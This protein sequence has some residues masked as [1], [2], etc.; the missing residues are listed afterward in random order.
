MKASVRR[1]ALASKAAE[2]MELKVWLRL[3]TCANQVLGQ[4]RKDLQEGF[5]ATLPTFDLLA[6][7]DRRPHGP[8]MSELSKRLMVS[9]GNISDLVDRVEAKGLVER[10]SDPTDGRVQRIYLTEAGDRLFAELAPAH[11]A[12]L[13]E[14][15]AG[16]DEGTLEAM[17]EVLGQLKSSINA[18]ERRRQ[19]RTIRRIPS[20][21]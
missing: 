19:K 5:G 11:N 16:L 21:D 20:P 14:A 6:Q 15:M 18:A 12:V 9:K 1:E 3:L 13:A 2:Q 17:N 4:L 7:L 10:R 8:T